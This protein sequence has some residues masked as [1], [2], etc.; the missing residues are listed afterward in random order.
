[1]V[2]IP[3]SSESRA[4][5]LQLVELLQEYPRFRTI[6]GLK[7]APLPHDSGSWEE[8]RRELLEAIIDGLAGVASSSDIDPVEIEVPLRLLAWWLSQEAGTGNVTGRTPIFVQ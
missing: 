6:R 4:V 3:R 1:M 7:R 2:T 5:A 8:E